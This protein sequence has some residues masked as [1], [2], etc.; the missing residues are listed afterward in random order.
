MVEFKDSTCVVIIYKK[1][2]RINKGEHKMKMKE[3]FLRIRGNKPLMAVIISLM[4]RFFGLI[5]PMAVVIVMIAAVVEAIVAR[6][7]K[8][9]DKESRF[10]A[11][12][13]KPWFRLV[14]TI[15]I[16][17]IFANNW[18]QLLA[19][20]ITAIAYIIVSAVKRKRSAT[21]N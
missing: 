6:S 11:F 17:I 18:I 20:V 1:Y 21:Q 10:L 3:L 14:E 2:K 12:V 5:P 7:A 8:K 19:P 4:A 15:A 9:K 13:R 16:V